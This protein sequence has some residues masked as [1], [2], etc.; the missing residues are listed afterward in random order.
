VARA[1]SPR[2]RP[3]VHAPDP[4]RDW[5]LVARSGTNPITLEQYR[6]LAAAL[7][8]AQIEQQLSSVMVTSA[9]PR[10]G[11]TLTVVNLALTL[12]ESYARR[13]LLIDADLRWPSVHQVLG[14]PNEV[15]LTEVLQGRE[16]PL[17]LVELSPCLSVLPSGRPGPSPLAGLTSERMGELLDECEGRF[18][19]VLLDT[20]PVGLLPDA[21]LLARMLR[22]VVFV[23]GAHSTPAAVVERAI[24]EIGT[25]CIIGTVLNG[26]DE[27]TIPEISYYSTTR[28]A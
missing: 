12:S 27:R 13:V 28:D 25:E 15:G 9:V 23:I 21:R 3:L 4:E 2:P 1:A 20:A 19:W 17:P 14:I 10:E 18:D 5:R 26:V 6:R 16:G 11:K 7:H 22:A 8:D 24:A